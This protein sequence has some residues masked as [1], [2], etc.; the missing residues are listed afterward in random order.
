MLPFKSRQ[1]QVAHLDSLSQYAEWY[2]VSGFRPPKIKF[3]TIDEI[4]AQ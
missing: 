1:T 3:L 2:R 4:M